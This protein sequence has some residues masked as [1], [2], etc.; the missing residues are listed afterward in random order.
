MKARVKVGLL[1]GAIGFVLNLCVA[2]LFGICGPGVSLIAGAFA[3]FFASRQEKPALKSDGAKA[4]G[5]AGL[6]AGGIVLVG[7]VIA[8]VIAL[9]FIQYQQVKPLIGAVPS[10]SAEPGQQA[11]YYV[12]GIFTGLCFGVVGVIFSALAG[13][14]TGFLGTP[15][16]APQ[17]SSPVE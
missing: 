5:I 1:V 15:D 2:S 14:G 12:S 3:G 6:I 8:A 4:G 10:F 11:I 16:A 7:Q 13:A 9:A 17:V